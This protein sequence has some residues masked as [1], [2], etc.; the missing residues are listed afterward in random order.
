MAEE[1]THAEKV[2]VTR[3]IEECE[4][5]EPPDGA[6]PWDWK[7]VQR[8]TLARL[9][10]TCPSLVLRFDITFRLE[11]FVLDSHLVAYYEPRSAVDRLASVVEGP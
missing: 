3:T 10:E 2:L 5:A 9:R 11:E 1:P 6:G 7:R 8:A 4:C